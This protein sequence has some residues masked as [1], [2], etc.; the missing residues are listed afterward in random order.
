MNIA[1]F[2]KE[3]TQALDY[4][5]RTVGMVLALSPR[6]VIVQ[7]TMP[8]LCPSGEVY[9]MTIKRGDLLIGVFQNQ[10]EAVKALERLRK[11]GF[12]E[13]QISLVARGEV[14]DVPE[15]V[16]VTPQRTAGDAAIAGAVLGSGVG[17]AAGVLA[18]SLIPGLTVILARGILTAVLGGA[19]LGAAVGTFA[20]P[21]I[22]MGLTE[23]D[24]QLYARHVEEGRT[25]VLVHPGDRETDARTILEDLGSCDESMNGT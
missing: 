18:A 20:G 15:A 4:S 7:R 22:A 24:A 2:L 6:V 13:S 25:V 8:I 23:Q 1:L 12:C 11:A 21:F 19:A 5:T 14:P 9:A 3:R 16:Q 10:A 17:A